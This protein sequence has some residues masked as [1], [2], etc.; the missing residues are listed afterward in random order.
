MTRR[1]VAPRHGATPRALLASVLWAAACSAP[2][3]SAT[4]PG[5]VHDGPPAAAQ[6][7]DGIG[8]DLD[9][10]A[11]RSSLFANWDPFI[12]PE[13]L[14]VLY[15]WAIGTTPGGAELQT[16]T[17]IGGATSA[18]T[19]GLQLPE[20]ATLFVSVRA[21]DLAGNL[22]PTATSDGAACSRKPTAA[23]W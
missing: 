12:D 8:V 13:G 18:V 14:P 16:W 2:Q 3:S 4:P 9:T 17:P 5:Q 20:Q 19:Q 15:E 7:R 22:S 11:M 21:K 23:A 10:Q 1:A 6:V